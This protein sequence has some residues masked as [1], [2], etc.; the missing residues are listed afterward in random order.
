M[1]SFQ[2]KS[3]VSQAWQ[4]PAE[5]AR[6]LHAGQNSQAED[7]IRQFP[8]F[9]HDADAA[10]DIIYEEYSVRTELY[11]NALV[12]ELIRRFPQWRP[13]LEQ[14]FAVHEALA[15]T[16]CDQPL[17]SAGRVSAAPFV[18]PSHLELY[19][20][21]GRGRTSIVY[22]GWDQQRNHAVAVKLLSPELGALSRDGSRQSINEIEAYARLC[23][24]NVVT[25]F[26]AGENNG[27]P[28]LVLEY[29]DGVSLAHHQ[30]ANMSVQTAVAIALKLALALAHIHRQQAVHWDVSP[31]NVLLRMDGEPKLTDFGLAQVLNAGSRRHQHGAIFGTPSYMAPELAAGQAQFAGPA[32]DLYSLGAVLYQ[33]LTG[34]PPFQ[35]K[36]VHETLQKVLTEEVLPP[37]ELVPKIPPS[38]ER[39][40]LKCLEKNP[41]QRYG[42]AL[43]LARDLKGH[44]A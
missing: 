30:N 21:I 7:F 20:Q 31:S 38:L 11:Q 37:R 29:V 19:H 41:N 44:L 32:A 18:P 12:Q 6:Q 40:I 10:L 33:M 16:V 3:A 23:H 22:L 43:T 25:L 4:A 2:E 9:F 27:W 36:T 26:E 13:Q 39:I 5:L 15:D 28:F 34:R 24:P 17:P 14:Q 1:D 8:D 42:E 35:G